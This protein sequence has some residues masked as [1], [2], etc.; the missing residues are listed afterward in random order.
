[1]TKLTILFDLVFDRSVFYFSEYFIILIAFHSNPLQRSLLHLPLC[2]SLRLS[3]PSVK[4]SQSLL[5]IA[6]PRAMA[7]TLEK[8]LQTCSLTWD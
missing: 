8:S 1:L 6:T 2:T 3:L 4:I 7:R 5:K